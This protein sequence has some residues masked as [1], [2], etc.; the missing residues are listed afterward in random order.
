MLNIMYSCPFHLID[1]CEKCINRCMGCGKK[2]ISV[3]RITS[4]VFCKKCNQRCNVISMDGK[5]KLER[6]YIEC[7]HI[8]NLLEDIPMDLIKYIIIPMADIRYNTC[9]LHEKISN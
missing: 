1:N 3:N 7:E 8:F 9:T 2:Y 5:C 4:K 6:K